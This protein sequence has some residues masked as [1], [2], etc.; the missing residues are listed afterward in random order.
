MQL[1]D[2]LNSLADAY[3]VDI[4][5]PLEEEDL[6][7]H[8]FQDGGEEDLIASLLA[9][10]RPEHSSIDLMLT[11]LEDMRTPPKSLPTTHTTSMEDRPYTVSG[12]LGDGS[13]HLSITT[14]PTTG[15]RKIA[16]TGNPNRK[17]EFQGMGRFST[18][19][20]Y[21][22]KDPNGFKAT[23]PM[24]WRRMQEEKKAK[25]EAPTLLTQKL[26][27]DV[28]AKMEAIQAEQDP[29]K[30]QMMLQELRISV[31]GSSTELAK[32]M[33]VMAEDKAGVSKYAKLLAENEKLDRMDPLWAKYQKDSPATTQLR[34]EY[35]AAQKNVAVLT[36]QMLTEN[37]TLAMLSESL[38]GF[39][40]LQEKLISK[41]LD[42]T[43]KR[44]ELLTSAAEAL[45][46]FSVQAL[47]NVFPQ[48]ANNQMKAAEQAIALLRN[49]ATKKEWATILD[50]T[51]DEGMLFPMAMSG[52]RVAQ[53]LTIQEQMRKTG[54]SK[55]EVQAD[56]SKFFTVASDE[57]KFLEAVNASKK[58]KAN[59]QMLMNYMAG[60]ATEKREMRMAFAKQYANEYRTRQMVGDVSSWSGAI[61][62]KSEPEAAKILDA[63]RTANG[64]RPVSIQEF[65]SAYV[66]RAP[67]EERAKRAEF[68]KTAMNS[69]ASVYKD[70]IFGSVDLVT[71]N[72]QLQATT[73][74]SNTLADM[75]RHNTDKILRHSVP[76]FLGD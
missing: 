72:T 53:Q 33:R 4:N 3:F 24:L 68:V 31:T 48:V 28:T 10:E 65:M 9:V 11:S 18:P 15:H 12:N 25:E 17:P 22:S 61:N 34:R 52:S 70:S 42:R 35:A 76:F 46:P 26:Q 73:S 5:D 20:E 60:S 45:T 36:K 13:G 39:T 8:T 47:T 64:N 75:F 2:Q 29:L 27:K 71:L 19:E 14:D 69:S 56:F 41:E 55:D 16:L 43:E 62:L 63:L 50:P 57:A 44:E 30:K 38:K 23:N 21:L 66:G 54:L 51:F 58:T 74:V 6:A 49:P 32:Q 40:A 59:S 67:R 7:I 37:P 1:T